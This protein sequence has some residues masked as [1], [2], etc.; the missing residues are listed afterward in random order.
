VTVPKKLR[1]GLHLVPGSSV[2]LIRM[3]DA[4]ILLPQQDEFDRATSEMQTI[5]SKAGIT[6]EDVLATLP[7]T[8][9]RL[10]KQRYG[11]AMTSRKPR[12]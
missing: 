3:G 11:A 5:L 7:A 8:R 2:A 10:F 12:V 1:R 4:L 6:A 9:Q